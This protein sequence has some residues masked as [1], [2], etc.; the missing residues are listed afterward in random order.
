M[1]PAKSETPDDIPVF[2]PAKD[3]SVVEAVAE[4]E[5]P[6][7]LAENYRQLVG[8]PYRGDSFAKLAAR[9]E[10]AGDKRLAAWARRQAAVGGDVTPVHVSRKP[11]TTRREG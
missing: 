2:A 3:E 6:E 1:A 8:D 5:I 11:K 7:W 4:E 10:D 9:S